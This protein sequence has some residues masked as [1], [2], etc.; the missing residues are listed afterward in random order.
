MSPSSPVAETV[1]RA[2]ANTLLADGEVVLFALRPSGWFIVLAT[3]PVFSVAVFMMA[4]SLVLVYGMGFRSAF[5]PGSL[6][7]ICFVA[8]V[9]RAGIAFVQWVGRMYVLTNRRVMR[10]RGLAQPVVYDRPL[11]DIQRVEC[12]RRRSDRALGLGSLLFHA[13]PSVDWELS[14]THLARPEQVM[15]A[16]NDAI[17]KSR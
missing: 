9:L 2:V 15:E 16:V 7:L 17:R 3:L 8:I 4:V 11:Q 14:W 1:D 10:L 12:V 13:G 6:M 5:P